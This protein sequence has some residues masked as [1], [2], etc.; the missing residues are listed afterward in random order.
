MLTNVMKGRLKRKRGVKE[1]IKD[2]SSL[3][4]CLACYGERKTPHPI[5]KLFVNKG[6]RQCGA[7]GRVTVTDSSQ[8]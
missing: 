5:Q 8:C 2:S 7:G 6:L 3:A 4:I 1:T